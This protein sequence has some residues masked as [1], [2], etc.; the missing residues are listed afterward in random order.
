[1]VGITSWGS[2]CGRKG[3]PGVYTEVS[4]YIDWIESKMGSKAF[5]S[6]PLKDTVVFKDDSLRKAKLWWDEDNVDR[7]GK[8]GV[9]APKIN[10]KTPIC[11]PRSNKPCCSVYGLCGSSRRHCNCFGCINFRTLLRKYINTRRKNN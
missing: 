10:G 9:H 11:N 7:S 4:Q 1:M 5:K 2:G 6:E 3:K 8:C